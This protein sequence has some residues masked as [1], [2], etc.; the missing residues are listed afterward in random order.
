MHAV[1]EN[2][3]VNRVIVVGNFSFLSVDWNRGRVEALMG[4]HLLNAPVNVGD[5]Y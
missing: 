5:S 1:K 4:Q 2:G 3:M